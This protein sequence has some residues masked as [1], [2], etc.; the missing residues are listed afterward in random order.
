M[1]HFL[2]VCVDVLHAR[3]QLFSHARTLTR[4]L[5]TEQM[6]MLLA[7]GHDKMPPMGREPVTPLEISSTE[8]LCSSVC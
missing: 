5:S 8:P 2:I 1:Q 4:L 6:L 7:Q 3:K